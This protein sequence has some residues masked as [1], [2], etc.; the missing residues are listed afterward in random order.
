MI[1]TPSKNSAPTTSSLPSLAS[2]LRPPHHTPTK[3]DNFRSSLHV[4]TNTYLSSTTMT[5]T[6]S[7]PNFSRTDRPWRSLQPG[8]YT[9]NTYNNT[10]H[11]PLS[12]SSTTS[13]PTSC[14]KPSASTM[15]TSSLFPCTPTTA[16]PPNVRS[17]HSKITF[18]PDS[19]H[20]TP[21]FPPNN[22]IVSFPT[23]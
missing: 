12:T 4:G 21:T 13:A 6:P 20:A 1:S 14:R 15:L 5:P 19:P 8:Q 11:P 16:T 3:Q 2:T 17:S 7:T 18:A 23:P 9:M 10:V 22:G